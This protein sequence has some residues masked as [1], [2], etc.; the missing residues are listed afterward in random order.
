MQTQIAQATISIPV[1]PVIPPIVSTARPLTAEHRPAQRSDVLVSDCELVDMYLGGNEECLATLLDRH[2]TKLFSFII[3]R[4][5][6]KEFAEDVFQETCFKAIRSLKE[7]RYKEEDKFINWIMRIARNY[8]IDHQ[9]RA[10][11]IRHISTVKN[12]DGEREDIFNVLEIKEKMSTRHFEK[13]QA[14]RK[15]RHL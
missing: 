2:K 13:R 3:R 11:R 1:L 9:R 7:G 15:V 6:Y 5:R 4:A 10:Q 8:I 12:A 14:H